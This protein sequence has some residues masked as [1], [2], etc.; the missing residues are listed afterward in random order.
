MELAAEIHVCSPVSAIET[1]PTILYFI[2]AQLLVVVVAAVVI[3]VILYIFPLLCNGMS[4][5]RLFR[6]IFC[7]WCAIPRDEV[8]VV[9]RK[10]HSEGLHNF[11]G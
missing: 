11:S 9:W 10:W 4:T 5:D 8:T 3:T 2:A 6:Y 7:E 1:R